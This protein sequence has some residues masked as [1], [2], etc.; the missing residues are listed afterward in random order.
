M[1]TSP[2][3]PASSGAEPGDTAVASKRL[4]LATFLDEADEGFFDLLSPATYSERVSEFVSVYGNIN[5]EWLPTREQLSA[6]RS[7]LLDN[8]IPYCDFK[9]WQTN[10]RHRLREARQSAWVV[11]A[12]GEFKKV[13]QPGLPSY[14]A[15]RDSFRVFKFGMLVLKEGSLANYEVYSSTIQ[16][17][18]DTFPMHWGLVYR[19]DDLLR[20]SKLVSYKRPNC[21]WGTAL[22]LAAEDAAFW[23][24][25]VD[26]CVLRILA[27]GGPPAQ[28]S[29]GASNVSNNN[30][31]NNNN[32]GNGNGPAAAKDA[33]SRGARRRRREVCYAYQ[34]GACP[35][36]DGTPC[37]NVCVG[38]LRRAYESTKLM[39]D[40]RVAFRHIRLRLEKLVRCHFTELSNVLS[41]SPLSPISESV[42]EQARS[43]IVEECG[44]DEADKLPSHAASPL[45]GRLWSILQQKAHDVD[46]A[47]PSWLS[48]G[49]SI[50]I[51]SA[52]PYRYVFP[53]CSEANA[54]PSLGE[55]SEGD[56]NGV[57]IADYL[58]SFQGSDLSNYASAEDLRDTTLS[59]LEAE[60]QKGFCHR[61]SSMDEVSSYVGSADVALT[62]LGLRP[63][64]HTDPVKYRIIAD[65][66]ANALN[67]CVNCDE[68]ILL[69]R[70]QDV[71]SDVLDLCDRGSS[72]DEKGCLSLE[73]FSIDVEAAFRLIP[74]KREDLKF[75]VVFFADSYWVFDTL[76]FGVASSPVIWCR[77]MAQAARF[78]QLLFTSDE[79]RLNTFMDDPLFVVRGCSKNARRILLLVALV[80]WRAIGIPFAYHKGMIGRKVRWVGFDFE[81]QPSGISVA[82]PQSKLDDAIPLLQEALSLGGRAPSTLL[83]KICGK[84]CWMGQVTP[85]M[86]SLLSPVWSVVGKTESAWV[87][88]GPIRT[89]LQWILA[90]LLFAAARSSER[91]SS[92]G[93][94]RLFDVRF[95]R[96]SLSAAIVVDASTTGYGGILVLDGKLARWF[97]EKVSDDDLRKFSASRGNSKFQALWET[98]AILIAL[99]LWKNRLPSTVGIVCQSDSRSALGAAL[100]L[101]SRS[102]TINAVVRDLAL[103]AAVDVRVLHVLY[104]HV[105]SKLNY[106]ADSLSRRF[107]G[108]LESAVP[109]EL[110]GV[111]RDFCAARDD[112]FWRLSLCGAASLPR[113]DLR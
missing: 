19:A 83:R 51:E 59:L 32:S 78:A 67:R 61:F 75:Q 25:H 14:E 68:H 21:S 64:P 20:S 36:P 8:D 63:K 104:E 82:V 35:V 85:F 80:L 100:R 56:G 87:A 74:V 31:G 102:P 72:V 33:A 5:S 43:I 16:R 109:S 1:K 40:G 112:S 58:R 6:L 47:V 26:L 3:S 86:Y 88:M 23:R 42:V 62:K 79:L 111:P 38:G 15:W 98:L 46:D 92:F 107:E 13:S 29:G 27:A 4:R 91:L 94:R 9:V 11:N 99:R 52:I 22:A 50:G 76:M 69:P 30:V 17:L 66:R 7:R 73:L 65:A 89:S 70:V 97:S 103:D 55:I 45:R 110:G 113:S 77:T 53:H 101:R 2:T 57:D 49:A 39:P 81:L 105:P 71:V 108:S 18:H 10:Q 54:E 84:C 96:P 34:T 93:F 12:D 48:T 28:S 44:G 37:P 41:S 60:E 106:L 24:E 90:F 95:R